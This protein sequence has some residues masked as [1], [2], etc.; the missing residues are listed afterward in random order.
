M[1]DAQ[2]KFDAV[3]SELVVSSPVTSGAMFG[4]PCLKVN[5]KAFAC[6]FKTAMAF[7]LEGGPHAEALALP[8]AQLFDPS[9]RDRPMRK[10]VEVPVS[11]AELWPSL[12]QQALTYVSHRS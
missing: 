9:G 11:H 3:K 7:K 5:G 12:A 4:K 8:G 2:S 10:W 6:L 1:E